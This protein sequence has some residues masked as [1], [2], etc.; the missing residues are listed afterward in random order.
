MIIKF[1]VSFVQNNKQ[2]QYKSTY[3]CVLSIGDEQRKRKKKIVVSLPFLQGEH[4]VKWPQPL[5]RV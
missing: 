4:N 2:Q 5:Y 1:F 3:I